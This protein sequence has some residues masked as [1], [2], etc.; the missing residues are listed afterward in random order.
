M[1]CSMNCSSRRRRPIWRLLAELFQQ[2]PPADLAPSLE[3]AARAALA[4]DAKLVEL[5]R[6]EMDKLGEYLRSFGQGRRAR[7]AYQTL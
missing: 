4:S 2:A 3:N 5:A 1:P 6:A 7:H